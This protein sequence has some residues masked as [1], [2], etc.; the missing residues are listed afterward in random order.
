MRKV[1]YITRSFP[2]HSQTFVVNQIISTINKGFNVGV[3]TY[4]LKSFNKSSQSSNLSDYDIKDATEIIDYKIPKYRLS[5][6]IKGLFLF[7]KYYKYNRVSAYTSKK[8]HWFFQP[9]LVNFFIKYSDVDVFHIHFANAGLDIAAMKKLG[10]V[11][12]DLVLTLHG[13]SI[14]YKNEKEKEGLIKTYKNLFQQAKYI[15]VNSQYLFNKTINLQCDDTKLRII[16]MG[17]DTDFFTNKSKKLD[18]DEP[19]KLLSV[20]RLIELKGHKYGI[21]SVKRLVDN[22]IHVHYTIIGVGREEDNLKQLV[23]NLDIE[24]HVTFLGI[25]NQQELKSQY[26]KHHIFLM[27]SITDSQDRSEAQGVVTIEAQAMGL[28]IVAFDSGGVKST[29]T[30]NTGILV[31]EKSVEGLCDA[32]IKLSNDEK[33]YSEMSINAQEFARNNFSLKELTNTVV[34][35]YE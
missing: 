27:T 1:T 15:T 5:R 2:V 9:Y 23:K 26:G 34:A 32:I 10:V 11:T 30:S 20:G 35:L 13:F 28:P 22:D 6:Y 21:E 31:K 12:G 25:K 3:L 7:F 29:F 33:L 16:P 24:S 18:V 4:S 19:I 17:V 8:E 14:H